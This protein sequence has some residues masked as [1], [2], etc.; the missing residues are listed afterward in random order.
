LNQHEWYARSLDS[1][2]RQVVSQEIFHVACNVILE[3]ASSVRT[4]P[5]ST[6]VNALQNQFREGIFSAIRSLRMLAQ[7]RPE[8][9][10]RPLHK[11]WERE[12]EEEEELPPGP[13]RPEI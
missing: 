9:P 10:Q 5:A 11:P 1:H 12:K 2:W 3:E 4:A 6:E 8:G 13:K 7:P